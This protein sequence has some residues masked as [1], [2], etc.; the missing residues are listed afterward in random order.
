MYHF[1]VLNFQES[2]VARQSSMDEV[3]SPDN[4]PAAS[5][6]AKKHSTSLF[7]KL[8][9]LRDRL[10]NS[11]PLNRLSYRRKSSSSSDL[12]VEAAASTSPTEKKLV[13]S[14]SLGCV[15]GPEQGE[16]LKKQ[17][18]FQRLRSGDSPTKAPKAPAKQ[19]KV[20]S[21]VGSFRKNRRDDKTN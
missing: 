10:H 19:G 12:K 13:L 6:A 16:P 15:L 8:Q 1:F 17:R 11:S 4:K 2:V 5:G 9:M 7:S 20:S 3:E 21:F 18:L 14:G